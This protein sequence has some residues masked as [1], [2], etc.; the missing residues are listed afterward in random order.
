[1]TNQSTIAALKKKVAL[2][3]KKVA[4]AE[5]TEEALRESEEKFKTIFENVN[6]EIIYTTIDGTIVDVNDKVEDIFGYKREEII[7]KNIAE[8]SRILSPAPARTDHTALT[9]FIHG[10]SMRV[11]S[12][13]TPRMPFMAIAMVKTTSASAP[14]TKS[15]P[16]SRN[17]ERPANK[18]I[19]IYAI[20]RM[21]IQR[22]T[23]P[24]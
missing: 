21:R 23:F 16:K 7:G 22:V 17:T 9:R 13:D 20:S 1:M 15:P 12:S 5:K 14:V 11:I 3:E 4:K 24:Y 10:L 18:T 2:L 19:M 8:I 6:D